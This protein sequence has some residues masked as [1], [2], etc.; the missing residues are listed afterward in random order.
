LEIKVRDIST[1]ANTNERQLIKKHKMMAT[2]NQNNLGHG[3]VSSCL[4]C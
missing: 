2:Y 3:F 4:G 1:V